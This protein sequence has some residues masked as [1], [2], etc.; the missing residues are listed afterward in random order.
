MNN[1]SFNFINK[2]QS[3]YK[4][5]EPIIIQHNIDLSEYDKLIYETKQNIKRVK[6]D[7]KNEKKYEDIQHNN[8]NNVFNAINISHYT[9]THGGYNSNN[10]FD[11]PNKTPIHQEKLFQYNSHTQNRSKRNSD[12]EA[13]YI[14]NNNNNDNSSVNSYMKSVALTEPNEAINTRGNNNIRIA[15]STKKVSDNEIKL[16]KVIDKLTNENKELKTRLCYTLNQINEIVNMLNEIKS[17]KNELELSLQQIQSEYKNNYINIITQLE[18]IET[19]ENI[20][21]DYL[22]LKSEN[23]SMKLELNKIIKENIQIKYTLFKSNINYSNEQQ[24]SQIN[25]DSSFHL[26]NL[27]K[28][29]ES[30][31]AKNN[32]LEQDLTETKENFMQLNMLYNDVIS[33]NEN[34]LNKITL[35]VNEINKLKNGMNK[36]LQERDD[37]ENGKYRKENE[38]L[39]IQN[40]R[41]NEENINLNENIMEMIKTNNELNKVIEMLQQQ[42]NELNKKNCEIEKQ[43]EFLVKQIEMFKQQQHHTQQQNTLVGNQ[44]VQHE[45]GVNISFD[46]NNNNVNNAN[47]IPMM[48]SNLGNNSNEKENNE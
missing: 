9:T 22:K 29:N 39:S 45:F 38:M 2:S 25:N 33:E 34:A 13:L 31:I 11:T 8:D 19:N 12:R 48:V 27:K 4:R 18:Q 43:N 14:N 16:R 10:I 32:S 1:N 20:N 24:Q 28:T 5:E 46:N 6:N 47:T 7:L 37:S 23:E 26:N 35:L 36:L 15:K 44:N 42:G 3:A 41:L 21:E 17:Q 40:E 30:L